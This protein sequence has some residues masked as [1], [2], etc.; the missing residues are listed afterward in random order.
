MA[1]LTGKTLGRYRLV[2]RLGRGG[3]AEVYKGYQPSMDRYVA[4]KLMHAYLAE[5]ENFVG[6]FQREA[7]AIAALRHPHIVQAYDFDIED[8]V[9]FMVQEFIGGG[10]LKDRLRAVNEQEEHLPIEETVRIMR[11]LCDAIDYAHAQGCI[12]RDIKPDNIMFDQDGRPV[13]TDFGISSIIGGTRFTA[14][15]AMIGTPAYMS[16]EQGKGD[17]NDRRSDIYSLGVVLYEMLTGQVPFDADTPFAVVLK[18]VNDALPMPTSLN[19]SLDPAIERVI[20][21]ALAKDPEDRYQ[22]AGALADD[23]EQATAEPEPW[24]WP[25]ETA[26]AAPPTGPVSTIAFES[27]TATPPP[28]VPDA[29]AIPAPTPVDAG[30]L[31]VP[32]TDAKAQPETP[33]KRQKWLW[34]AIPAVVLLLMACCV[35]G[36][37][38]QRAN[39]AKEAGA[40]ATRPTT[41]QQEGDASVTSLIQSG[42]ETIGQDCEG[43]V[44]AAEELF[45]QALD[46]DQTASQAY[47]GL[48]ACAMCNGEVPKAHKN[49][50]SAI[51]IDANNARAY[52]WR[53]RLW[54]YEENGDPAFVDFSKA[55]ELDPTMAE[56]YFWRGMTA[57]WPLEDYDQALADFSKTIE[58]QPAFSY[59]YLARG[60]IYMYHTESPDLALA[61]LTKY[62]EMEP[63]KPEGYVERGE[64]Y[65]EITQ[66]YD[67]AVS[68]FTEAIARDS[69]QAYYYQR[70]AA[71]YMQLTSWEEAIDDYASALSLGPSTNLYLYRG[72]ALYF[73]GRYQEALED[74]DQ[75]IVLGEAPYVGAAHHG[76][77]WVYAALGQ[78]QD[79]IAAYTDAS[80]H[81]WDEYAWPFF[82]QTHWLVDRAIAYREL[83]QFDEALA[84]HNALMAQDDGHFRVYYERAVTYIAM[85]ETAKAAEDLR[86][87][88][89]LTDDPDW[90]NEIQRLLGV[91]SAAKE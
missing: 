89:E 43:D 26:T 23:L 46:Q 36:R 63:D 70:R 53:G 56:A 7:K 37:L 33:R 39:Q 19:P 34:F 29:T 61:D 4:I 79:A 74:L 85:G 14:T 68:E 24:E 1:D 10:T 91:L 55:I 9:Y 87:A 20:L 83:G 45:E 86:Q 11:A 65:L 16:P 41:Q 73:A 62:V 52:F 40:T 82:E 50:E 49:L 67:R 3:M 35:L 58:L 5:D 84:D 2:E 21:R 31:T 22:T 54:Y 38:A 18:H 47:V 8:D 44:D 15:G 57:S 30:T 51:G 76:K 80:E 77:G 25:A 78:H 6:R 66:D 27:E 42:F 48:A 17:S 64:V 81:D 13:L 12:H 59:A 71:A 69:E 75:S 60:Q 72:M 28:T 88:L 32:G 90:Q